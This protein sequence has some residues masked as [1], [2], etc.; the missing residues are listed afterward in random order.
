MK[1]N[2]D[3]VSVIIP[4]WNGAAFLAEAIESVKYQRYEKI[5]ILVID[6]GS[7]D[8]T[9]QVARRFANEI[10]YIHRPHKGVAAAR[11]RGLD[12]A[13]GGIIAFLDVDDLW[14]PYKLDLQLDALRDETLE[15]VLGSTRFER[16]V[17]KAKGPLAKCGLESTFFYYHLSS[18]LYRRSVFE[19]VGRFDERL[20]LSEDID[21]F[22]R[23][24]EAGVRA[25]VLRQET[26]IWREHGGNISVGKSFKDLKLFKIFKKSLER[27]ALQQIKLQPL[28]PLEGKAMND[29]HKGPL[30]S[31]IIPVHNGAKFLPSAIRAVLDQTYRP[32]EIIVVDDGS[33]DGS[34]D[35]LRSFP[36]VLYHR[37]AKRGGAAARNIGVKLAHGQFIAFLD[38]DDLWTPH[39]LSLQVA[40][41]MKDPSVGYSLTGEKL[42]LESNIQQPRWLRTEILMNPHP[43]YVP[44]ALMVKKDVF[45]RVGCFDTRYEIVSDADWLLRAKDAGIAS[46]ILSEVLLLKRVHGDNLTH[47][48]EAMRSELMKSFKASVDRRKAAPAA[49]TVQ[50]EFLS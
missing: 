13:Q 50:M 33:E 17:E 49:Q 45:D 5:E 40:F 2:A 8:E 42:F 1:T 14:P 26:T 28:P 16:T 23:A 4:A 36:E 46:G 39:K 31:V 24:R 47:R 9:E 35:V 34:G 3:L 12:E 41:H 10:R 21:W 15:M 30:V 37:Q 18:G 11:N 44:S 22:L 38:A 19:T 20:D 32:F 27:R 43:S 29:S 48:Q 6:D 7:T 25:K